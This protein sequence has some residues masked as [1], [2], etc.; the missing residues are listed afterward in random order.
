MKK[1]IITFLCAMMALA[2][3]VGFSACGENTSSDAVNLLSIDGTE[4][5]VRSDIDYYIVAEP[6]AS[7]K[8]NAVESL[9]FVGDLQ[10]LY[11]G[12]KGY[13]QA[14]IV[15]KKSLLGTDF[16][17]KFLSRVKE[18]ESWLLDE[19]TSAETIVSAV[20]SHLS[21]G[22]SPMFTAKNLSKSVIQNCGINLTYSYDDKEEIISFMEE[23][24]SV[25][26]TS[27]GTPSASFFK[28]DDYT[29]SL[30][31]GDKVTVYAPDG[32]PALGL[33]KLMAENTTIDGCEIEYNIV[34]ASTIQTYVTGATPAAD[35]CVLP[36]NLAVKLLG[37]GEN[38]QLVGTLTH[39]N[40]FMLSDSVGQITLTNLKD[41]C[42]KTV[43]VI[44]LAAVPGL[45]FKVIL[46]NNGIAYREVV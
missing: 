25:S 36:V 17:P 41:L 45:T 26:D 3:V 23:F 22:M 5:G 13:P 21:E 2:S 40:L 32:A 39:G 33:A 27:F 38:Y 14:V 10:Q 9:N 43:G 34:D 15:A 37:S 30:Y 1:I 7:T 28:G 8:V 31:D 6:V 20:T 11:G 12:T 35:I 44:N 29:T 16:V 4:V 18:G 19:S 46:K 24:N 42:G